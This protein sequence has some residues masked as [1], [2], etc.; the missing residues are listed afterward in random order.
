MTDVSIADVAYCSLIKK[1]EEARKQQTVL[2]CQIY[3]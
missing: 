1:K 2:S 3:N